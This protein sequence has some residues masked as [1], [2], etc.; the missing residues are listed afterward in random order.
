MREGKHGVAKAFATWVRGVGREDY[1]LG[2]LLLHG[3]V[4]ELNKHVLIKEWYHK[5]WQIIRIN[6]V[7]IK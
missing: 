7:S 5:Q 4:N 2:N 1:L 3:T 6:N